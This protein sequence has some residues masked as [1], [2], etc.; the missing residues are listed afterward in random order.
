MKPGT[1][2]LHAEITKSII[3]AIER[4]AGAFH[5]PWQGATT[6]KLPANPTTHR[7]YRGVNT[8]SLWITAQT[9]GYTSNLWASFKQW[10]GNDFGGPNAIRNCA[11][12][13]PN[14]LI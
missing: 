3:A 6:G 5:M 11:R 1:F 7:A 8:L 12:I 10:S 9:R 13:R 4:G 14:A 2:D